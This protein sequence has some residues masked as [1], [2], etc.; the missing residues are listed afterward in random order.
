MGVN[1]FVLNLY[2][3]QCLFTMP[4]ENVT[5]EAKWVPDSIVSIPDTLKNLQTSDKLIIISLLMIAGLG[6][7]SLVYKRKESR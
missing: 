2:L 7:G 1:F 4:F 5:I 3:W 6:I